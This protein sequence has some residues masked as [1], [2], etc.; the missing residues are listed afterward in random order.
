[1][2]I[3]THDPRF[4]KLRSEMFFFSTIKA[5]YLEKHNMSLLYGVHE[6]L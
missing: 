3:E 4:E 2:F 1:M 6:S 5:Y